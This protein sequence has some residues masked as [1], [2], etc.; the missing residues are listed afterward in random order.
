[1]EVQNTKL[2]ERVREFGGLL[3]PEYR[4][5][6]PRRRRM[7]SH[8]GTAERFAQNLTNTTAGLVREHPVPMLAGAAIAGFAF[9]MAWK[10][11]ADRI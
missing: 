8:K 9:G 1:M 3:S 4:P 11:V 7:A 2:E 5:Y 6:R 10:A